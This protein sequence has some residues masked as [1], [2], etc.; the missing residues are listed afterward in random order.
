[1]QKEL[2]HIGYELMMIL[3]DYDDRVFLHSNRAGGS[4]WRKEVNSRG[5][6]SDRSIRRVSKGIRDA[7]T[8]HMSKMSKEVQ[9][10]T[11]TK[12]NIVLVARYKQFK[13]DLILIDGDDHLSLLSVGGMTDCQM[14]A[15]RRLFAKLTQ[16]VFHNLGNMLAKS[17]A[18]LVPDCSISKVLVAIKG[19]EVEQQSLQV[20]RLTDGIS[21]MIVSLYKNKVL[22]KSSAQM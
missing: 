12:A 4:S 2:S 14:L 16:I 21:H 22:K 17:T 5:G 6:N 8:K 1:V 3:K 15:F 11:L 7:Q 20:D 10:K 13:Q 19:Q 9:Q 18:N